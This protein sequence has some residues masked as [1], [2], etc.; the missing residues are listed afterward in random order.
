MPGFKF[1]CVDLQALFGMFAAGPAASAL[2]FALSAQFT[3]ISTSPVSHGL[4]M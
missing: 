3:H 1:L 4:L 2:A